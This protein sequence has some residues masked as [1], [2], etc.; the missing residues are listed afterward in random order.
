[1]HFCDSYPSWRIWHHC[2][3]VQCDK[4]DNCSTPC[5]EC[6]SSASTFNVFWNQLLSYIT[7][8]IGGRCG[9]NFM[10]K[11]LYFFCIANFVPSIWIWLS[12]CPS[13]DAKSGTV[14][15]WLMNKLLSS[16][17]SQNRMT[18]GRPAW[19]PIGR[20]YPHVENLYDPIPQLLDIK[21]ALASVHFTH[22]VRMTRIQR[23]DN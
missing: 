16:V 7:V 10:R 9:G 2:A 13:C 19:M 14:F 21:C 5:H 12:P 20:W 6:Y 11:F 1:M 15:K 18:Y 3:I 22:D 17:S 23:L 8:F 4:V